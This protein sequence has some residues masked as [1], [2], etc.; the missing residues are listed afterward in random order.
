[1]RPTPGGY[2]GPGTSDRAD[3]PSSIR[4]TFLGTGGSFGVPMLGCHCAVC[5][6][7]SPYNRRTR[8]SALLEFDGRS[9]LIDASP[10]LRSQALE[11][12]VERV[13]AVLF[14]HDHA[15]HVGGL[16]DLR[17]FNLRQ[18]Q[19]LPCYGRPDTLEAIRARF[20]YIFSS[21]PA[22]GS[23]PRLELR[24]VSGPFELWGRMIQPLDVLHGHHLI[25][26]YRVGDLAYVTDASGLPE[27]TY[28]ALEGVRVLALNALRQEPHV[29]HFG[30][31]QAVETARR[32]GAERTYLIHMG[33]ELEHESTNAALPPGIE[34]A[35]DG[36]SV[37]V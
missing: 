24:E 37:C 26:G 10:D 18:R 13:D 4:L 22:L 34:L 6:S 16:D 35:Y 15:D 21:A 28:R 23:R 5:R 29:L 33:H 17:A 3:G 19:A 30:L 2:N 25:T 20:S 9:V 14:T 32:I 1:M 11:R 27:D 31:E 7:S 8:T 12:G 36:L